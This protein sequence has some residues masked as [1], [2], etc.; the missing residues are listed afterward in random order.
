MR[1]GVAG[2][3]Q[4]F[5]KYSLHAKVV[6]TGT[7]ILLVGGT[8]GFLIVE[9]NHTLAGMDMGERI[10]AASFESVTPRTAGFNTTDLNDLSEAGVILTTLLMMVGAAPGSTGGGM[11]ITTMAVIIMGVASSI[12]QRE[13]INIFRRRLGNDQIRRAFVSGSPLLC[14]DGSGRTS[15][16]PGAAE[17][18]SEMWCWKYFPPSFVTLHGCDK[19][20]GGAVQDRADHPDVQRK[21]GR[22]SSGSGGSRRRRPR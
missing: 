9:R 3:R 19:R 10:L 8:I 18:S 22:L 7:A 14:Y 4:H 6:L 13:E 17:S 11:K 5:R 16:Y 21:S 12:R 20:D 15:G 2:H 1:G